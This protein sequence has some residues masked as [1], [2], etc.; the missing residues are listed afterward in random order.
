MKYNIRKDRGGNR[1]I[2]LGLW[3]F[4]DGRVLQVQVQASQPGSALRVRSGMPSGGGI[5]MSRMDIDMDFARVPG[6]EASDVIALADKA[7]AASD[8]LIDYAMAHRAHMKA[9]KIVYKS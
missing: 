1:H 5:E 9:G 2:D 4:G 8:Y 7:L 3:W 6:N